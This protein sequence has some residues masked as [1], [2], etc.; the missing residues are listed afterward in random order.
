MCFTF[1][2]VTATACW[3]SLSYRPTGIIGFG[4]WWY[5]SIVINSMFRNTDTAHLFWNRVWQGGTSCICCISSRCL[6]PALAKLPSGLWCAL[7]VKWYI[8]DLWIKDYGGSLRMRVELMR[9]INTSQNTSQAECVWPGQLPVSQVLF[10]EL[11]WW[12]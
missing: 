9:N 5:D 6:F 10:A 2:C 8:P 3:M 12:L 11:V 4:A 1:L 7:F